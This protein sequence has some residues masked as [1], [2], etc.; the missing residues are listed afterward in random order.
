MNSKNNI[1]YEIS[2]KLTS[3]ILTPRQSDLRQNPS[4]IYVGTP[5]SHA[6][7]FFDHLRCTVTYNCA[8]TPIFRYVYSEKVPKFVKVKQDATQTGE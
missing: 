1:S 6:G 5:A 3:L 4:G 2:F 8:F 7:R